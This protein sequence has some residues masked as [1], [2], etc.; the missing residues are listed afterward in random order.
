VKFKPDVIEWCSCPDNSLRG[1][2]MRCKHLHAI[3]FVIRLGTLSDIEKLPTEA[4]VRKAGITK[5]T[6]I[7]VQQQ[8]RI[9]L[10]NMMTILFDFLQ[11]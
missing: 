10:T 11:R 5:A 4:K 8:S 7:V 2:Q 1:G 3:E 6:A 9:F